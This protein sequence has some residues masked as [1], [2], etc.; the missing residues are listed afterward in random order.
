MEKKNELNLVANA[1]NV[2]TKVKETY[3]SPVVEIV[4]VL[5]ERGFEGSLTDRPEGPGSY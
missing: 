1:K 2:E 3:E 5:V 4:E